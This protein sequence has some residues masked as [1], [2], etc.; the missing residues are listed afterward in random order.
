VRAFKFVLLLL[1]GLLAACRGGPPTGPLAAPSDLAATSGAGEI[2][3]TWQD[4][5]TAEVG[6]RIFR[7]AE[8]DEAFPAEQ[9]A[10]TEVDV[11]EYRDRA[12]S[13]DETYV[14][15][16]QAFSDTEEGSPS[17]ESQ[18]VKPTQGAGK[19]KL[20]IIRAG[21]ASGITSSTP[22]GI[23]CI[24]PTG[25]ACSLDVDPGTTITLT[26]NPNETGTPPSVFAGFSGACTTTAL[27]CDIVMDANKDVRATYTPAQPGLTVQVSGE[28]RVF[29]RVTDGGPYIDCDSNTGDCNETAYWPVGSRVDLFAEAADGYTFE[30]WSD[31]CNLNTSATAPDRCIFTLGTSTVISA[32]F[33]EIPDAPIVTF[34][35]LN[36]GTED[37]T[38]RV[39]R[40]GDP[41]TR[42]LN[43]TVQNGPLTSLTLN[44]SSLDV[45]AT[46]AT[47]TLPTTGG[48]T[49]YRLEA[50]NAN[51]EPGTATKRITTGEVPEI[52]EQLQ[53]EPI[54]PNSNGTYTVSFTP[55]ATTPGGVSRGTVSSY[56]YRLTPP[57]GTA[58]TVDLAETP[59]G[60]GTYVLTLP[61]GSALGTYFLEASNQFGTEPNAP[62]TGSDE[63]TIAAQAP[64][65]TITGFT[66]PDTTFAVGG[67][68][69]FSWGFAPGGATPT[70]LQLLQDG[71][72]ALAAC[73]P[74]T[75]TS[76][77]TTCAVSAPS[78]SFTLQVQP[79]GNTTSPIAITTGAA[80]ATTITT[81]DAGIVPGSYT[82]NWTQ[83]GTATV[84]YTLTGPATATIPPIP[85]NATSV[86]ITGAASG[87]IYTLTATNPYGASAGVLGSDVDSP[88]IP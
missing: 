84:S 55:Q 44:G 85:D 87:E 83:A 69:S 65:P 19:V 25:G 76:I 73:Q 40:T 37:L 77:S 33:L 72:P 53:T 29:D 1:L 34:E 26:A 79:G 28:G 52:G 50:R 47:V 9:L 80:P 75:P 27:T 20:T 62:G 30:G 4:N 56:T 21:S 42:T 88:T 48:E 23:T 3:L 78:T 81:I 10:Q 57:G 49:A 39:S 64:N 71:V 70:S 45:G 74:P 12:I 68:A 2:V 16:V 5:S 61:T 59:A 51:P 63:F 86:T 67:T 8:A 46:S 31:N 41:V 13:S 60:S 6:F 43:W 58:S 15:R 38:Y 14:Y 35:P 54:A 36:S 82:I 11:T 22:S 32:T 17:N 7:K 18:P 24:N 66:A